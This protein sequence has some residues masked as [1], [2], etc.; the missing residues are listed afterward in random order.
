MWST[1]LALHDQ[2]VTLVSVVVVVLEHRSPEGYTLGDSRLR[3]HRSA[4]AGD[5]DAVHLNF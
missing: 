5:P 1:T 2:P 4:D 3:L